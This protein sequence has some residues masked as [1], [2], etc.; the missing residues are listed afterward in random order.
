ME[1]NK[2]LI[3]SAATIIILAVILY[4]VSLSFPPSSEDDS[5]G[6]IGKVE[7]FRKNQLT[8][9]DVLLSD[10]L[11]KDTLA[12]K[13]TIGE[14]G[15]FATFSIEISVL[16]KGYW[17]PEIN[18]NWQT[19]E[20]KEVSKNLS[21]FASFIDNNIEKTAATQNVLYNIYLKKEKTGT[22]DVGSKLANFV[23]YVLQ[24]MERDSVMENTINRLNNYLA[25]T[26]QVKGNLGKQLKKLQSLRD[27]IIVDTF[28]YGTVLGDKKKSE[29][30]AEQKLNVI[31]V[32]AVTSALG[33][34]ATSSLQMVVLEKAAA[35]NIVIYVAHDLGSNARV[36]NEIDP[37]VVALE[38]VKNVL[39]SITKNEIGFVDVVEGLPYCSAANNLI[40][41][42]VRSTSIFNKEV[43]STASLNVV[44]GKDAIGSLM[45]SRVSVLSSQGPSIFNR[46]VLGAL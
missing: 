29:F 31:E 39:G 21:D 17:L 10:D 20:G 3:I 43:A 37:G 9:K 44:L 35:L 30:A 38:M 19:E 33:F 18:A 7:K 22:E 12:L 15:Q 46:E 25:S 40:N 6:T 27:K 36:L 1:K 45:N 42:V 13:N 11:L 16:I 34:D 14:I 2:K 5:K 8:A 28:L 41:Y 26:P 23:N 32:G 24:L 4:I